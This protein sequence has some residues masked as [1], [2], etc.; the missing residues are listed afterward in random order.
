[1]PWEKSGA[2]EKLKEE[3][4]E[5]QA[6]YVKQFLDCV[7]IMLLNKDGFLFIFLYIKYII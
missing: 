5:N 7:F 2:E 6:G 4:E 1:M 3:E